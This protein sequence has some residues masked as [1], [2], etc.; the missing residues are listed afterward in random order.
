MLGSR[1]SNIEEGDK[2]KKKD[3]TVDVILSVKNVQASGLSTT[4]AV[5]SPM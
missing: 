3:V 4:A 2:W 1:L 5:N